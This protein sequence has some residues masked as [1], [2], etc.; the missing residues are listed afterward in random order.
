LYRALA[1]IEA[2]EGLRRYRIIEEAL[3]LWL[4]DRKRFTSGF[5]VLTISEDLYSQLVSIGNGSAE[6][7]LRR[8][9]EFYRTHQLGLGVTPQP[10][11]RVQAQAQVQS[12]QSQ[13]GVGL[14]FLEDNPWIAVIRNRHTATS[15]P[16]GF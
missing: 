6:A 3:S 8:L 4:E 14:D 13:E 15:T 11:A 10:Q 16:S 7:G 9:L 2:S 5:R 1:I 12:Q